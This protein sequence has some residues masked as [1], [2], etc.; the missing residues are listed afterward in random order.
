MGSRRQRRWLASCLCM[1]VVVVGS[2]PPSACA[3]PPRPGQ[4]GGPLPPGALA[5]LQLSAADQAHG[6]HVSSV[7][8]SPDGNLLAAAGNP[9]MAGLWQVATGQLHSLRPEPKARFLAFSADGKKLLVASQA[10]T[11]MDVET[12]KE[13]VRF[14]EAPGWI[15]CLTLSPDGNFVAAGRDDHTVA[16]WDARTGKML[17]QLKGH[18]AYVAAVAFS[19]DSKTLATGSHDATVRLWDVETGKQIRRLEGHG[20]QVSTLAFARD[21]KTLATGS[22]DRTLRLWDLATGRT[23]RTLDG[24]PYGVTAVALAPDGKTLAS[25]GLDGTL[26]LWDLGTG[27][28]LRQVVVN[29]RGVLAVAFSPDGK[30]VA[31]GGE[32]SDLRLWNAT[33]GEALRSFD[34]HT[35]VQ[36][37]E[38]SQIIYSVAVSPDG[39]T[40]VTGSAD[41]TIRL[42]DL[43]TGK[44]LGRLGRQPE[45]VWSVVFAPDGKTVASAG[46]R[47]G[48]VHLWELATSNDLRPFAKRHQ[49]GI[50]RVAFS[51]D[52]K[53]LAG[54]GGSFDPTICLWDV[55]TGKDLSRLL[56]HTNFVSGVAFNSDGK[57]LASLGWDFSLRLWDV[58]TAQVIRTVST[59]GGVF[60]SMGGAFA[61][62]GRLLAVGIENT[63]ALLDARNG[64]E[65]R[66][67]EADGNEA[68]RPAFSPDGKVLAG[69]GLD[70]QI[71]LWEVATG[72]ERCQ[73]QGQNGGVMCL[74]FDPSGRLLVTGGADGTALVWDVTGRSGQGP[75][76]TP[77]LE[78]MWQILSQADARHAHQAIWKLVASPMQTVSFIKKRL[79]PPATANAADVQRLIA[80]LDNERFAMRHKAERTL[81]QMGDQI[82]P[83]LEQAL[84]GS[85]SLEGR[86]RVERLLQRLAGSG[87]SP[88]RLQSLRAIEVLEHIGS[89]EARATL[90]G[91]AKGPPTALLTQEARA[92]EERLRRRP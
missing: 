30:T 1:I 6:H 17:R 49:G 46:R 21:G 19:P 63:L 48:V 14:A 57:V 4:T 38:R 55:A 84:G 82:Q 2:G 86:R 76:R 44:H 60:A 75:D 90:A 31:T 27:K 50:G 7:A 59:R 62:N 83:A 25:G 42:W 47:D 12:G 85:L 34:L 87:Q 36:R 89:P 5:R 29:P 69:R 78:G 45:A 10:M 32:V 11:L 37:V 16:L 74:A 88:E 53:V 41:R 56:G 70:K 28:M 18:D 54:A 23:L 73:F 80:D 26:R 92:A 22:W 3:Q 43:A 58:A 40:I 72:L 66:R 71:H 9:E 20:D 51:P 67:I 68:P 33:T 52:G 24:H 64:R 39:K 79:R 91:L 61:S 15:N 8:F 35:G 81:E 65:V 77:D 13:L